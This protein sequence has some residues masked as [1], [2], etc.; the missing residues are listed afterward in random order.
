V[1]EP[2]ENQLVAGIELDPG[3]AVYALGVQLDA[4]AAFGAGTVAAGLAR[5]ADF[6]LVGTSVY[7]PLDGG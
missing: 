4:Q 1:V 7:Q 5:A 6:A 2:L 3:L